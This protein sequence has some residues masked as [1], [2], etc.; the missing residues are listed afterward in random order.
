MSA[1][2]KTLVL[3]VTVIFQ[4]PLA[5]ENINAAKK[6]LAANSLTAYEEVSLS[7][8]QQ[9]L[10]KDIEKKRDPQTKFFAFIFG[11][12][13]TKAAFLNETQLEE[14]TKMLEAKKSSTNWHDVRNV[15]RIHYMISMW[16]VLKQ[17][18]QKKKSEALAEMEQ[19][20]DLLQ[21]FMF[22]EFIA[23]ER[24][25]A[26][27]WAMLSN[28]QKQQIQS[29]AIDN[30]VKKNI[31]HKRH[32][33]ADKI[34]SKV[35]GKAQNKKELLNSINSLKQKWTKVQKVCEAAEKFERQRSM[36]LNEQ[37]ESF[38]I[39]AWSSYKNSY[40]LFRTAEFEALNS[41]LTIYPDKKSN[42]EKISKYQKK[43]H[44]DMLKK[45]QSGAAYFLNQLGY[46]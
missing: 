26:Q 23:K 4:S 28:K 27:F 33:S 1:L 10:V 41:L 44:N 19:W 29:G 43:L 46:K 30:K 42:L 22:Q 25:Q 3:A 13:K 9:Q 24:F 7:D 8:R 20:L 2:H 45:Y 39:W 35:L 38:S 32:F 17:T 36:L 5:A 21:K 37:N 11:L 15:V 14:L 34:I 31:G 6:F 40:K 12:N 18:D 16:E